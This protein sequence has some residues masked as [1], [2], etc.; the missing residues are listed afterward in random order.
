[1]CRFLVVAL[2]NTKIFKPDGLFT[3][4]HDNGQ[5]KAELNYKDGKL[6]SLDVWKPNG[7]K[8]PVSNIVNSNGV[9][10]IYNEDGTEK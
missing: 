5:K 9:M 2:S 1:M 7:E 4:W 6:L 10:V 8:S 3:A